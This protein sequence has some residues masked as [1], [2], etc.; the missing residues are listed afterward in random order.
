VPTRAEFG[1]MAAPR[2]RLAARP[3]LIGAL[4][5]LCWLAFAIGLHPLTL[6]DEGRY[7]GVAW[8]MLRSGDWIVPTENGLPFFHKPPLFYWITAASMQLFGVNAAAARVAPLLAS[9]LAALALHGF[10]RRRVGEGLAPAGTLVLA[11]MP[12]FFAGAQFANLDMLVASCIAGAIVC[13]ADAAL[14]LRAGQPHRRMLVMAWACAAL[15][16]LAKGLIG[17]VLP[18]LVIVVWLAVTGQARTM[19]RLLWPP[20]IA[21]FVLIAAP[22]FIAV[23]QR[24]PEFARYFFIHHHFERFTAGGFNNAEPWWFFLVALPL[25]ALPWSLWLVRVRLKAR[26]GETADQIAVRRLLWTWLTCI[27]VFFSLP[28]SKPVGYAMPALFP[29]AFLLA[30]PALAAWRGG[31][32]RMRRA[33]GASALVA[34]MVCL[35]AV[36]WMATR[37]RHD[38]TALARTLLALRGPDD[39]VVFVAEYFFDIP[40]HARLTEPVA[41]IG[42]WQDAQIG[43]RDNWRRELAEAAAFAPQRGAA[44]LVDW[45]HGLALRCGRAP[46]WALAKPAD[47]GPLAALPHAVRVTVSHGVALWRIEPQSCSAT[48]PTSPTLP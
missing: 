7:S 31:G 16:V 2:P 43:K 39:P 4:A 8:E 33:A 34:V 40:L 28:Q 5:L 22:W 12:F 25:L 30:E 38:D 14:A 35:G 37:Y 1:L 42:D 48:T 21:L 27:V 26:P 24:Y 19:L 20:A 15:G 17:L 47:E 32:A 44:L 29:L 13:A 3:W 36:G 46:L 18:G 23:Q 45:P 6:P 41:V 11:T 10:I 9:F